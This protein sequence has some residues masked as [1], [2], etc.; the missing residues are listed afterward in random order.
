M[1][2]D[3]LRR[4]L[5]DRARERARHVD[6]SFADAA[7]DRPPRPG[8]LFAPAETADLGVE[9]LVLDRADVPS[10]VLLVPADTNPLAG[11]ADVEAHPKH[12]AGPLTIRCGYGVWIDPD[13]LDPRDRTGT[14]DDVTLESALKKRW[15]LT[16]GALHGSPLE[17][18]VDV[19]PEYQDWVDEILVP[20]R[21]ALET[22]H[23]E[24]VEVRTEETSYAPL[25]LAWGLAAMLLFA[26]VGL[27][28][29]TAS[30]WEQ[31][32]TAGQPEFLFE[33]RQSLEVGDSLRGGGDIQVS[34]AVGSRGIYMTF[35]RDADPYSTF[36]VEIV[37]EDNGRRWSG[38]VTPPDPVRPSAPREVL[39][40]LP[41][42]FVGQDGEAMV[43]LYGLHN[44]DEH[45]I[46]DEVLRLLPEGNGD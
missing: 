5:E 30:L 15:A 18:E 4:S 33:T 37:S 12:P 16:R 20:A 25:R 6:A 11:S 43:R 8:D 7:E 2:R 32:Q 19:D 45:F 35:G 17:R 28:L 29:W 3:E 10:R 40:R 13:N 26:V 9:W 1:D 14:V 24:I 46:D 44:G 22:A 41:A 31:A 21:T 27:S 42:D 39:L 38:T 23:R 36:R 34:R